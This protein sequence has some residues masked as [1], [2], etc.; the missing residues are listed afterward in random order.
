MRSIALR[1]TSF[2]KFSKAQERKKIERF[3]NLMHADNNFVARARACV[4]V[5][6]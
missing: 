6:V 3:G 2:N 1:D 5:C 4:C